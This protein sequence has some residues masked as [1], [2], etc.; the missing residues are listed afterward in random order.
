MT[1]EKATEPGNLSSLVIKIFWPLNQNTMDCQHPS[2][3]GMAATPMYCDAVIQS[4][5]LFL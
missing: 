3:K 5:P 4:E 2:A 1:R